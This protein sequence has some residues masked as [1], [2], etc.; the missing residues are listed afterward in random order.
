VEGKMRNTELIKGSTNIIL[1]SL[2][3]KKEM[4]GYEMTVKVREISDGYLSY[5]EGTI[6][7]ALKRLELLNLVESNWQ[8]SVDGP[9]RKYYKVTEK[10]RKILEEQKNEWNLFQKAMNQ[11]VRFAYV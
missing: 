3:S 4:Y 6:Y 2:L 8:N 1:L 9:K 7:P 11:L 5:K 10:G